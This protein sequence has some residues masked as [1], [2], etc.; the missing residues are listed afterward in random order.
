M[1]IPDIC[2]LGTTLK[3]DSIFKKCLF[4]AASLR[5]FIIGQMVKCGSCLKPGRVTDLSL[6]LM[7]KT[8]AYEKTLLVPHAKYP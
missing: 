8:F 7:C 1:Q 4:Y 5:F 3:I 2:M 6:G